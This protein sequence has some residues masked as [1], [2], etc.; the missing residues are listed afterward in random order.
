VFL[1]T[2]TDVL[3]CLFNQCLHLNLVPCTRIGYYFYLHRV[4]WDWFSDLH[5]LN[6]WSL[7]GTSQTYCT[8]S[9]KHKFTA[10]VHL[11]RRQIVCVMLSFTW[12][13]NRSFAWVYNKCSGWF[14][15]GQ[16]SHVILLSNYSLAP[17]FIYFAYMLATILKS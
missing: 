17:C 15:T 7:L 2:I 14:L 12:W 10:C 1:S 3:P 8:Y 13:N 4:I 5:I 11:W 9:S 16:K 6:F